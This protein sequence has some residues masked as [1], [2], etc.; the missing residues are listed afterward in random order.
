MGIVIIACSSFLI[1]NFPISK[2]TGAK[3]YNSGKSIFDFTVHRLSGD[4]VM[5]SWHTEGEPGQIRFE[6]M[7]KHGKGIP[8]SSLGSVEP[9]SKEDNSADYSFIDVNKFSDSTFY[10]LKK[11]DLDS[12]VFYSI[13][14][15]IEGAGKER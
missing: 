15:G 3:N 14:K 9:K 10:C 7:R 8:F 1:D 11:T 13:T 6:V 4:R 5:I 12:V 2:K